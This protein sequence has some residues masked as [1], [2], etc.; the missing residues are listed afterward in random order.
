MKLRLIALLPT[1]I[2]ATFTLPLS[3]AAAQ[4]SDTITAASGTPTGWTLMD[5]VCTVIGD[6]T[7]TQAVVC[8]DLYKDQYGEAVPAVEA[9]CQ[10]IGSPTYF[11]QCAN[12]SLAS[13]GLRLYTTGPVLEEENPYAISCGHDLTNM[14][15]ANDREIWTFTPYAV[16]S[17][18]WTVVK[19]STVKIQLPG[20]GQIK[21]LNQDLGSG[22]WA[23]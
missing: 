4:T 23:P 18:Q 11:P 15:P 1:V 6:D 8:S 2:A 12:I 20:T 10:D 14:C 7:V 5:H 17:D 13:T 3:T 21:T 16:A 22:H 9:M 19:A